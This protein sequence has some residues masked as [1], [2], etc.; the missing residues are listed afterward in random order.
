MNIRT[1]I[2]VAALALVTLVRAQQD[3]MYTMYMW[4]MLSIMPGYAGS[5]D[6]LNVSGMSR[7]Q[8]AGIE[9]APVTHTMSAHGPVNR[10]S[11]AMGLTLANDRIGRASTYSA[12]TDIAY[13]IRITSRTRLAFGLKAGMNRTQFAN[14]QVEGTDQ[15]DITFAMDQVGRVIPNFGF[16]VFLWS[17]RGYVGA[18]AP[19]LMRNPLGRRTIDGTVM[20]FHQEVPHYFLTGGYVFLLS[21]EVMFRPSAMLRF[22][23]GAPVGG[24]L[25]ANF[26]FY[27]KLWLGAAYR[28]RE[29]IAGIFSIQFT[30]NWRMGYAHDLGTSG[31]AS[32]ANGGHEIM[33]GYEPSM[34]HKKV[35][36]PR[37]F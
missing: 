12:F 1:L 10:R 8:W 26:L 6:L 18:S 29:S 15:R 32:R 22:V 11:L 17:G 35:R 21:D 14:T 9:G 24:D 33:L 31:I 27:S 23:Q 30:D 16:G 3:P 4:N 19:K 28:H 20:L 13:R 7:M 25:S 34:K 2:G 37:Y 5:S 36:S